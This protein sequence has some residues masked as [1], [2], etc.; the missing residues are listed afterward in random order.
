MEKKIHKSYQ[1]NT[2]Q[3]SKLQDEKKFFVV[4]AALLA[5]SLIGGFQTLLHGD[6]CGQKYKIAMNCLFHSDDSMANCFPSFP[7]N[8]SHSKLRL[9]WFTIHRNDLRIQ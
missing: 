3:R 1:L 6:N 8:P 2:M 4:V 7:S 5:Y 9:Y